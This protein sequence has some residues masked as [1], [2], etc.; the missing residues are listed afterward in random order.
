MSN[1]IAARRLADMCQ[2]IESLA[3]NKDTAAFN[4]ANEIATVLDQ[5]LD[6][7]NERLN[8]MALEQGANATEPTVDDSKPPTAISA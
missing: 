6:A 8:A 2:T 5:T 3:K 7:L 4:D 1:N